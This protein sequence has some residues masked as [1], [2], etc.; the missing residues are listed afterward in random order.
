MSDNKLIN[1]YMNIFS[2]VFYTCEFSLMMN[3]QFQLMFVLLTSARDR[4]VIE[5]LIEMECSSNK[6]ITFF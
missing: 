2:S 1:S 5:I 6:V 4:Y 3:K